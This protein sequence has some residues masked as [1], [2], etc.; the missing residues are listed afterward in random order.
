MPN[1]KANQL[2]SSQVPSL[3]ILWQ[4]DPTSWQTDS[5]DLARQFLGLMGNDPS[6]PWNLVL[7]ID[8]PNSTAGSWNQATLLALLNSLAS[9]GMQPNLIFHP[10]GEKATQDW[11]S[12][13]SNPLTQLDL[14]HEW[15]AM[16]NYM[17]IFNAAIAKAN[18]NLSDTPIKLPEFTSFI[19]EGKDFAPLDPNKSKLD[20]FNFLKYQL[21]TQGIKNPE[22]WN[23]GDWQQGIALSENSDGSP[24][25]ETPDSGVYMQIYDFYNKQGQSSN[26]LV[27]QPTDP[28]QAL[29]LGSTMFSVL[30]EET[31]LPMNPGALRYP[32]RAPQIF[33]FSGQDQGSGSIND[34]PVFGGLGQPGVVK[35]QGWN[36]DSFNQFLNSYKSEFQLKSNQTAPTLGIWAAEN[37]LD[38]L[39]PQASSLTRHENAFSSIATENENDLLVNK[40]QQNLLIHSNVS[41]KL[42]FNLEICAALRSGIGIYP[43]LDDDARIVSPQGRILSVSDSEYLANAKQ[44]AIDTSNW[45]ID[46]RPAGDAKAHKF[47]WEVQLKPNQRYALIAD[48]DLQT[49]GGLY[50]SINYANFDNKIQFAPAVSNPNKIIGFED[51]PNGDNDFNDIKLEIPNIENI[52]FKSSSLFMSSPIGSSNNIPEIDVLWQDASAL[53]KGSAYQIAQ[54]ITGNPNNSDLKLIIN[55]SGPSSTAN[56]T[57]KSHSGFPVIENSPQQLV[58]FINNIDLSVK[59]LGGSW[60]GP[61]VYHPDA[62][63]DDFAH[64]W[65][66]FTGT[67]PSPIAGNPNINYTLTTNIKET[68]EAYIDYLNVLN[69]Y[70]QNGTTNK[71][72]FNEFIYEYE[73]SQFALKNGGGEAAI[74]S[75]NSVVRRYQGNPNLL[76]QGKTPLDNIPLSGSSSPITNWDSQNDRAGWGA[77]LFYAQVYDFINDS[78]DYNPIWEKSDLSQIDPNLYSPSEAADLFANFFT[79]SLGGNPREQ[80]YN[81]NRMVLPQANSQTPAREF[82]PR[83]NFIFSYGPDAADGPVFYSIKPETSQWTWNADEFASFLTG[84]RTNLPPKLDKIAQGSGKFVS[85]VEDF[86]LGVWGADRALDAWFGVPSPLELGRLRNELI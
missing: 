34:A 71:R 3:T 52:L 81:I 42:I 64:D 77:D 17:A 51:L 63:M 57:P 18:S 54:L 62:T 60:N 78:T 84:L 55:I 30:Q 2:V 29:L 14:E 33:N 8:G 19:A 12:N 31:N 35:G 69:L 83:A 58:D 74:F 20:T 24:N 40:Y 32:N 85:G 7:D 41:G 61:I 16:V 10:D 70:L 21:Q 59:K 72:Y 75:S 11:I 48:S 50:S 28:S 49:S 73:N 26:T 79:N 80:I 25:L 39:V 6:Q 44:L 9:L 76:I 1:L 43:L 27:G 46:S 23:T 86:K 15:A 4:D 68:Y 37:A 13:P 82:D 47:T 65:S 38:V 67:A 53:D 66:G 56:P 45:F 5:D 22:P 36:I